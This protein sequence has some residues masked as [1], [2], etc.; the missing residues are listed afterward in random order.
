MEYLSIITLTIVCLIC[1][2]G[3][4]VARPKAIPFFVI[5]GMMSGMAAILQITL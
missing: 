4:A 2:Y 5:M 1:F 3:V